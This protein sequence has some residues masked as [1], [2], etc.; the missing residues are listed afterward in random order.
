MKRNFS[1]VAAAL[2][3]LLAARPTPA[4]E[5]DSAPP[6][7][8]AAPGA[9]SPAAPGATPPAA[10]GAGPIADALR[11][12]A[13][14]AAC[15]G[16]ACQGNDCDCGRTWRP[17]LEAN[18]LYMQRLRPNRTPLVTDPATGATLLSNSDFHFD[19][20]PGG[21]VKLILD[22]PDCWGIEARYF[23]LNDANANL[24]LG[25]PA[26]SSIATAVPTRFGG[27][28]AAAFDYDTRL[29]SGE[30]NLRRTFK[31]NAFAVLAGFRY[32]DLHEALSN[33]AIGA[34]FSEIDTWRTRNNLYGFQLGADARLW[35]NCRFRVDAFVRGGIYY[36]DAT[37]GFVAAR[38]GGTFAIS[39]VSKEAIAFLGETGLSASYQITP[40]VAIRGGYQFLWLSGVALAGEQVSTTGNF[41]LNG[42]F[43]SAANRGDVFYHGAS[44]GLQIRW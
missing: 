3:L 17:T 25:F 43:G 42:P 36:D 33:S 22:G 10:P 12:P 32:V 26:V 27:P 37:A 5:P 39:G 31:D 44:V 41:N 34:G 1:V 2:T 9:A 6:A 21:D 19:W 30:L 20:E 4:D 24:G 11:A 7:A 29:Q 15:S 18:L 38:S 14:G 13:I 35:S 40:H 16:G 23:W 28:A 8:A